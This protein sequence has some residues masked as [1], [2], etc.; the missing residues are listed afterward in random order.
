[1]QKTKVI[2]GGTIEKN[3][4]DLASNNII[5]NVGMSPILIP[6]PTHTLTLITF[7]TKIYSKSIF[8]K[9]NDWA[10]H[11]FLVELEFKS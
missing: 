9:S 6:S 8:N 5:R 10:K 2:N 3:D 7:F 4:Y 1:M 11:E